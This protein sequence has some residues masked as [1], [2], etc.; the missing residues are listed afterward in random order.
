MKKIT[1]Q[2]LFA[3]IIINL[4]LLL[5]FLNLSLFGRML[6]LFSLFFMAM[7]P[8][9]KKGGIHH[10]VVSTLGLIFYLIFIFV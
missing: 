9:G 2:V 1:H 6:I 10:R 3:A 5:I 7:L 8:F 4:I